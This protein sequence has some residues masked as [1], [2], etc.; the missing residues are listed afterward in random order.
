M[1][2][3]SEA[4]KLIMRGKKTQDR[5]PVTVDRCPWAVGKDYAVQPGRSRESVGRIA[6]TRIE[7]SA[8]RDITFAEACAEGFR[9]TADFA[10]SWFGYPDELGDEDALDALRGN[11]ER[12]WVLTFELDT[13]EHPRFLHRQSERGYTQNRHDA[14]KDEPEAIT[15]TDLARLHKG[16]DEAHRSFKQDLERER[17]RRGTQLA[18][19]DAVVELAVEKGISVRGDLR[20]IDRRIDAIEAKVLRD[21]REAA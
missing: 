19:L 9:T 15:D 11:P 5:R 20:A 14:L 13:S 3:T 1:I 7:E 18:R 8:I 4:A 2:F 16:K 10:R 17:T 21:G 6:V 12:V